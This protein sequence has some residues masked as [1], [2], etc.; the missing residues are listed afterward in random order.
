MKLFDIDYKKCNDCQKCIRSCGVKALHSNNRKVVLMPNFCIAC[1]HC[2]DVCP[3]QCFEFI[4]EIEK[5]KSHIAAGHKVIA[6]VDSVYSGILKCEHE[7]FVGG[8]K[9]LGFSEVREVG[10]AA[11]YVS[12]EYYKYSQDENMDNVLTSFCPA[13]VSLA[14][15]HYPEVISQLAPVVNPMIAHGKMIK[16]RLG[17]D[18]IVV[19]ISPC[20]SFRELSNESDDVNAVITFEEVKEWMI[21]SGIDIDT[22]EKAS[23]DNPDPMSSRLYPVSTGVIRAIEHQIGR[24]KPLSVVRQRI[25]INGVHNAREVLHA[26]KKDYVHNCFIEFHACAGG[27]C[28]GSCVEKDRGFAFKAGVDVDHYTNLGKMELKG[29]LDEKD[30]VCSFSARKI[31]QKLPSEEEIDELMKVIGNISGQPPLDCGACGYNTCRAKA[32]AMYQGKSPKT[33][34]LMY[35]FEKARSMSNLVMTNTPNIIMIVDSEMRIKEF[36]SKAEEVFRTSKNE[37]LDRYL[38]EFIDTEIL[39]KVFTERKDLLRYKQNWENRGLTV[40]V[41]GKFIKETKSLLIIIEDITDEE[42]ARERIMEKKLDT[43]EMAQN[44]IDK[45]M[46]TAQEIAGLLGETTAETKAILTRLR[47]TMLLDDFSDESGD[48]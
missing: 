48:K 2:I 3:Q 42:K 35:S 18:A 36:N 19:Y 31:E 26:I 41:T 28:N 21:D 11:A 34:C 6:S 43:V 13:F 23:F 9:K 1:G 25:S 30:L 20:I 15:K 16:K 5:V 32:I 17:K 33:M 44:V 45:Q 7:S 40:L 22:V 29:E 38:Y 27:C 46:R 47:D 24:E 8:L 37:A 4:S 12:E 14:E 39:C 10:E